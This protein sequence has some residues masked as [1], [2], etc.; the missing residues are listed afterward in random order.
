M[1]ECMVKSVFEPFLI[2]YALIKFDQ[3]LKKIEND[4]INTD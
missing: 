4:S 1:K 2:R 3:L